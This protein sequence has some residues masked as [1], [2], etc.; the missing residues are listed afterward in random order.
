MRISISYYYERGG[1]AAGEVASNRLSHHHVIAYPY[2]YY[3]G[4]ISLCYLRHLKDEKDASYKSSIQKLLEACHAPNLNLESLDS[5]VKKIVCTSKSGK[6]NFSLSRGAQIDEVLT[7]VAWM[8]MNLFTGPCGQ[9]RA[10]DPG[11]G[12][13]TMPVGMRSKQKEK[14]ESI[15]SAIKTYNHSSIPHE[16]GA[17]G[18]TQSISFNNV[19]YFSKLAN[20]FLSCLD[21]RMGCYDSSVSDWLIESNKKYY[22]V[23]VYKGKPERAFT[24]GNRKEKDTINGQFVVKK[25]HQNVSRQIFKL[26]GIGKEEVYG[27]LIDNAENEYEHQANERIKDKLARF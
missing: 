13:D 9:I 7:K 26:L 23:L 20:E 2:M 15:I 17:G 5:A 3:L 11:Q 24:D 14:L 1:T 4:V 6:K 25:E 22:K 19:T 21:S 16:Q 10:E 12:Y 27:I 18:S 8:P